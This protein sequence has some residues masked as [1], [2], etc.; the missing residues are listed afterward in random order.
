MGELIR[1]EFKKIR[2]NQFFFI[3]VCLSFLIQCVVIYQAVNTQGEEYYSESDLA[4]VYSG[5]RGLDADAQIRK[6]EEESAKCKEKLH[7]NFTEEEFVEQYGQI[8][9]RYYIIEH[10][11]ECMNYPEYLE[12]VAKQAVSLSY[13]SLLSKEDSFTSRNS[14]AIAECYGRLPAVTLYADSSA[15]INK[16][17]RNPLID[18]LLLICISIEVMT[19][20]VSEK[21]EGYYPLLHSKPRGGNA[22]YAAKLIVICLSL[23]G[24]IFIFY[25]GTFLFLKWNIGFCDMDIPVQS[26]ETFY[27][28]PYPLSVKTF[29]LC[30]FTV[31]AVF[32]FV[33]CIL[34]FCIGIITSNYAA[35]YGITGSLFLASLLFQKC[36][37]P[38]SAVDF[39]RETGLTVLLDTGHYF[40]SARNVNLLGFPVSILIVGI[41]SM[42]LCLIVS[43]AI[44][45]Y[46]WIHPV[47]LKFPG[48]PLHIK[49]RSSFWKIKHSALFY[50]EWKKL[51]ITGHAAVWFLC[52]VFV[53]LY[54][55]VPMRHVT[56][57]E[58]YYEMYSEKLEGALSPD[59]EKYLTQE[60]E[61]MDTAG[62]RIEEY[63]RLYDRGE[64][65]D[66]E[67]AFYIQK[68]TISSE[69]EYAFNL[70]WN[71]YRR[72]SDIE[73]ERY[74]IAYINESGWR[75]ICGADARKSQIRDYL[76]WLFFLTACLHNF[77]CMED[78]SGVRKLMK[79]TVYGE[80]RTYCLKIM[81]SSLL[82]G[83]FAIFVC[84]VQFCS[85]HLAWPLYG[86]KSM[87]F[88]VRSITSLGN[89]G[90][91]LSV[92]HFLIAVHFLCAAVGAAAALII[93]GIS[94]I[95]GK[96][97]ITL[98]SSFM[99]L[100]LPAVLILIQ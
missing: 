48:L 1:A 15:G 55:H 72:L 29:L 10:I 69:Q 22:I 18:L 27:Q 81:L 20:T 7:N 99:I 21:E 71:Q 46:C 67:L 47:K 5:I 25:G 84:L 49:R 70:A 85:V 98:I 12:S 26:L 61:W 30:Y 89:A 51:F 65:S 35:A 66:D 58:Y 40:T 19:L 93:L 95:T 87:Q 13:S 83:I 100:G 79:C 4:A 36:I 62:E 68:E 78:A 57:A 23:A 39:L 50:F 80:K 16:L 86:W 28:C 45:K 97:L 56:M 82:G 44:S 73:S 24:L 31:K 9:A 34:F 33:I 91:D 60:K 75:K 37:N 90:L 94:R 43:V 88:S 96:P 54:L 11:E 52:F 17:T 59:K 42:A 92:L 77:S 41:G 14:Q 38:H 63:Y 6:L 74:Q 53:I 64:I 8:M 2:A 32:L 76:I 3:L